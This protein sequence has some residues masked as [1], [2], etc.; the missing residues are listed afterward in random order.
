ML[1][2]SIIHEHPSFRNPEYQF[3]FV[4][5]VIYV[6]KFI[7]LLYY[8]VLHYNVY[9]VNTYV[10]SI[11]LI[12][13]VIHYLTNAKICYMIKKSIMYSKGCDYMKIPQF[14]PEEF[15]RLLHRAVGNDPFLHCRP[16]TKEIINLILLTDYQ[17]REDDIEYLMDMINYEIRK[18]GY[19]GPKRRFPATKHLDRLCADPL[20][21]TCRPQ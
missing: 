10:L 5:N 19:D 14:Y 4:Y 7:Y 8:N 6:F 2:Y 17:E 12:L 1:F 21:I 3:V 13:N 16:E 18:K 20:Y 11:Y 9:I 15:I